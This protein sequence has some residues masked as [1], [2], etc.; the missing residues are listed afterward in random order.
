[1]RE[2][3]FALASVLTL[4]LTSGVAVAWGGPDGTIDTYFYAD[5]VMPVFHDALVLDDGDY[6]IEKVWTAEGTVIVT[7]NIDLEDHSGWFSPD[8]TDANIDKYIMVDPGQFFCMEFDAHVEKTAM[9]D[10]TGEVFREAW[11]EDG[12][13][14]V[15]DASTLYGDAS[16]IDNIEYN[17]MVEVY[18]S[19]GLNR[20]ATCD[21]VTP[22]EPLSPPTCGWC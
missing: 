10:G 22:P 17:D 1:M 19:V 2:K 16:F 12:T 3:I 6:L 9:W 5:G 11:L 4:L 15:V 14:S 7:Q 8:Y 21:P 18:E 20:L 13:Y